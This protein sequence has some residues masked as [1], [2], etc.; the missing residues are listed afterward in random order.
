MRFFFGL[1][2][3]LAAYNGS[4]YHCH[5]Q[6][7][8][9]PVKKD[10]V[11]VRA[12]NRKDTVKKTPVVDAASMH[13]TAEKVYIVDKVTGKLR[14]K[15]TVKPPAPRPIDTVIVLKGNKK[16]EV[17]TQ[18][19]KA[20]TIKIVK[21]PETCTCVSMSVKASDSLNPDDYVN[22]QFHFKNNCKET[23]YI[24][25]AA[26]G[27]YVFNKNGTPAKLL[28]KLDYVKRYNYPDFVPL[29]P[30]EE[31]DFMFGDDPFFQY[32]L[33]S[34]W[35]YKFSFTYYNNMKYRQAPGK[36]YMCSEFRDKMIRVK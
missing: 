29:K 34:G 15:D 24:S 4:M 19:R 26:F 2:V 16:V 8:G 30:G 21:P 11:I 25:S 18:E 28:R 35:E 32:D 5:A 6:K 7:K 13:T 10:T 22:Y 17:I 20:D 14:L 31:Y 27:F 1:L 3:F 23:V 9:E 12:E 33:R 36:T